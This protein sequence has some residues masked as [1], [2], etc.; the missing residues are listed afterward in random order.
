[1]ALLRPL[2]SHHSQF[3]RYGPLD[4]HFSRIDHITVRTQPGERLPEFAF[5]G[6]LPPEP[7]PRGY[8]LVGSFEQGGRSPSVTYVLAP[9]S[10]I[11][12]RDLPTNLTA[13]YD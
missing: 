12:Q 2:S 7:M 6:D 1:M 5:L 9:L 4:A 3:S 13:T 11:R 8:G 10:I